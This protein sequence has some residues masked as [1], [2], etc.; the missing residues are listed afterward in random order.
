[1]CAFCCISFWMY[2]VGA[3]TRN[4]STAAADTIQLCIKLAVDC[5]SCSSTLCNYCLSV[6]LVEE[7]LIC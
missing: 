3:Q 6:V 2:C 4:F 5:I 7:R 1:M